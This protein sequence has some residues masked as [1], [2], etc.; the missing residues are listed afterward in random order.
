MIWLFVAMAATMVMWLAWGVVFIGLGSLVSRAC[1]QRMTSWEDVLIAFW[2]GLALTMG[3]LQLW[4]LILPIDARAGLMMM[5]LG[6]VGYVLH[7]HDIAGLMRR[8]LRLSPSM[9]MAVLIWGIF[10]VWLANRA[11]NLPL[12]P[13]SPFYHLSLIE[14]QQRFPIVP[15]LANLMEPFIYNNTSF[16]Y[17]TMLDNGLWRYH[18]YHFV[19]SLPMAALSLLLLLYTVRWLREAFFSYEYALAPLLTGL[20]IMLTISGSISSPSS[21]YI[22]FFFAIVVFFQY[23]TFIRQSELSA[24]TSYRVFVIFCLCI[25]SLTVKFSLAPFFALV[26]LFTLGRW[27]WLCRQHNRPWQ[28]WILATVAAAAFLGIPWVIRSF[29]ISGYA[30]FPITAIRLPVDWRVPD[31]VVAKITY[32]IR[33]VGFDEQMPESSLAVWTW[34]PRW[35]QIS[36]SDIFFVRLPL[37]W[38]AALA[39]ISLGLRLRGRWGRRPYPSAVWWL[40]PLGVSLL[41]WFFG[42]PQVKYASA[43]IWMFTAAVTLLVLR[44][45]QLSLGTKRLALISATLLFAVYPMFLAVRARIVLTQ[46]GEYYGFYGVKNFDLPYHTIVTKSG[47]TVWTGPD[48]YYNALPCSLLYYEGLSLRDPSDMSQGFRIDP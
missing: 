22:V 34:V 33:V 44:R 10:I 41:V 4:H 18:G 11:I 12:D 8:G 7:I 9:R 47:L 26:G 36:G 43:V 3:L 37:L 48:C 29:I 31:A 19:T 27:L 28:Y 16:L 42:A 45:A 38:L 40:V 21:D 39:V 25:L 2:M 46:P 32:S 23:I 13:D 6:S 1:G 17:A 35:W 20:L 15:G 30:A 24:A 5:A 14:W